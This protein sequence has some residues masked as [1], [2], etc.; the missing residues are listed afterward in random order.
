LFSEFG[1]TL[2]AAVLFSALVA[3]TLTPMMSSKLPESQGRNRFAL[4]VDRF[5]R[6]AAALYDRRLR[7]LI[8]R[9]WLV[10]A[11]VGALVGLG[12]LTFI[13]VPAEFAP[14]ADRGAVFITI[15]GPEGSSFEYMDRQA[16]RLEA[17]AMQEKEQYGD[18]E[19][20]MIRIPGRGGGAAPTGDVNSAR[21]VIILEDWS[22]RERS[23][24]E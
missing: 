6:R 16:R 4:A 3:L 24:R 9:P 15:E 10:I 22:R 14:A 5:F 18:I 12:A 7:S 11:A 17:I 19:R 20:V 21:A 1:F 2:A 8:R 13:T 23:A